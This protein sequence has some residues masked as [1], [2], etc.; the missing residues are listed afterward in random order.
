MAGNASGKYCHDTICMVLSKLVYIKK[1]VVLFSNAFRTDFTKRAIDNDAW[2]V[3]LSLKSYGV[4]T[5]FDTLNIGRCQVYKSRTKLPPRCH[6]WLY[7]A[8]QPPPGRDLLLADLRPLDVDL[9]Q[10]LVE[11]MVSAWG[12]GAWAVC[13]Q[14][15]SIVAPRL[16]PR[17]HDVRQL[18]HN[19]PKDFAQPHPVERNG[20][21]VRGR[22]AFKQSRSRPSISMVVRGGVV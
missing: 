12:G 4:L 10:L 18:S 17:C 14:G 15:G 19:P 7:P 6:C 22:A 2:T 21:L 16:P 11:A 1:I 8:H 3:Q 5:L 9:R 13:S 20:L